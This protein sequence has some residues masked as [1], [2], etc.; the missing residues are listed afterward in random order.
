MIDHTT[1]ILGTQFHGGLDRLKQ[2]PGQILVQSRDGI[3][4]SCPSWV[5]HLPMHHCSSAD[6]LAWQA[7]YLAFKAHRDQS[8][9]HHS[10]TADAP[11]CYWWCPMVQGMTASHQLLDAMEWGESAIG[12]LNRL[13]CANSIRDR[14]VL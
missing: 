11:W 3:L 1:S 5:L 7:M 2:A 4:A 13:S 10:A 9:L 12:I 14:Q 8:G 6:R